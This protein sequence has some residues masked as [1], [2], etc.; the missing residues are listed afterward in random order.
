MKKK[1]NSIC[2][3]TGSYP[4]PLNPVS[5][6][7]DQLVSTW[8]DQGVNCFVIN[9]RSLNKSFSQ[10]RKEDNQREW[11]RTTNKGNK[12]MVYS[13]RFLSCSNKNVLGFNSG[14]LTYKNYRKAVE[15]ELHR[16]NMEPDVLY[17]HFISPSGMTAAN[18]GKK[19]SIP[20]FLAF[21]ESSSELYEYIGLKRI[22]KELENLCGVVSV[23]SENRN[24]LLN[25]SIVEEDKI[26]VFPNS[27]DN[28]TFYKRDKKEMRKKF[29]YNEADFIVAFVGH[30]SHR[31]GSLRLS[32]AIASIADV[33]S[34]FIGDGNEQPICDGIL[35][36]GRV[37]HDII[38][39][40][41]SAA[42]IF[43]LPTLN[44]GCCNAII[45]AMACGLPIVSSADSFNDDILHDDNSIRIDP[46]DVN[47]IRDA[48][49]TL[50]NDEEL[51]NKMS[52]ASLNHARSLD[53]N[54]RAKNIVNFM[55]RKINER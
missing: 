3:I 6:F 54:N 18:L 17:G 24:R 43:V 26:E 45:E 34:I 33:K 42:D 30:Y 38:P 19:Y 31:K 20:S 35:H 53:I 1:I 32:E 9:P 16:L 12:V 10:T 22:S 36:T 14:I 23:S 44:E 27:I 40:M 8:A 28:S 7:V 37:A 39:E 51:R 2:I 48:I 11:I 46:M 4:T 25:Q 47:Q 13:P 55:L 29:G 50:K 5:T 41:L 52:Y 49:I 21:G 15:K